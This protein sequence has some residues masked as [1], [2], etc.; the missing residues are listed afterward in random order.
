MIRFLNSL[1]GGESDRSP[2]KHELEAEKEEIFVECKELEAKKEQILIQYNDSKNKYKDLKNNFI[3]SLEN[4]TVYIDSNIYMDERFTELFDL[5]LEHTFDILLLEVQYQEIYR[6]KKSDQPEKAKS[7]RRAFYYIDKLQEQGS[8]RI[9]GLDIQDVKKAYADPE[10]IERIIKDLKQG[11]NIVFI[12]EDRDLKI[13]LRGQLKKES[14]DGKKIVIYSYDHMVF[15]DVSTEVVALE[16]EIDSLESD[17]EYNR[18]IASEKLIQLEHRMEGLKEHC[19]RCNKNV[20]TY[21]VTEDG[22]F[23]SV[24]YSTYCCE[25]GGFISKGDNSM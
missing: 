25:C 1:I 24:N 13:R 11:K 14:L 17:I 20:L 23:G 7:A 21:T 9:E 16:S 5:L 19:S 3:G 8:L 6:C 15:L 4:A 12:T 22:D 10:L 2:K 18:R